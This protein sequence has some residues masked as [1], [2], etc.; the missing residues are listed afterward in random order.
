MDVAYISRRSR[1]LAYG[2][3]NQPVQ[4]Y[5]DRGDSYLDIEA[6]AAPRE[7][8][9]L[10]TLQRQR[11]ERMTYCSGGAYYSEALFVGGRRVVSVD[12]L[13]PFS[14]VE[15]VLAHLAYPCIGD[16]RLLVELAPER[17]PMHGNPKLH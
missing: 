9:G 2:W 10:A 17:T 5:N 15:D 3:S 1:N 11:R 16:E 6:P 14:I 4:R 12:G 7:Q 8:G 13:V